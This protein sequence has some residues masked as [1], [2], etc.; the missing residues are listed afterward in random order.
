MALHVNVSSASGIPDDI[1]RAVT[2]MNSQLP[3]EWQ[4]NWMASLIDAQQNDDWELK[5]TGEDGV[6][7]RC[8]LSG[9]ARQQNSASVCASLLR[10]RGTWNR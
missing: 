4:G 2:N 5:L 7:Q 1:S 8:T 6:S 3:E 10:L 9:I